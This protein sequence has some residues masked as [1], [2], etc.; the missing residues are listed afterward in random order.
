MWLKIVDHCE[1]PLHLCSSHTTGHTTESTQVV[2][3][4]TVG[5]MTRWRNDRNSHNHV[6]LN[7]FNGTQC[8]PQQM[9]DTF[10]LKNKIASLARSCINDEASPSVRDTLSRFTD[11]AKFEH[12][13]DGLTRLG[14]EK[15]GTLDDVPIAFH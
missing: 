1:L 15:Y 4:L 3:E 5:E 9:T 12:V 8:V 2:G 6:L 11:V 13:N 14:S 10:L 7:M